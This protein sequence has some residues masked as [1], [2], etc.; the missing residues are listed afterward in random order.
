MF[1]TSILV[2]FLIYYVI[3]QLCFYIYSESVQF[4][5]NEVKYNYDILYQ[6]KDYTNLDNLTEKINELK[7]DLISINSQIVSQ[8]NILQS[9]QEQINNI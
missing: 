7:N 9:L 2:F 5:K 4:I 1:L 8:N 6:D 3:Y